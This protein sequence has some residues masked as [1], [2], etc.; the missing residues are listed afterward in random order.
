[1]GTGIFS[2]VFLCAMVAL[3][4]FG[5]LGTLVYLIY[6]HIDEKEFDPKLFWISIGFAVLVGFSIVSIV[7]FSKYES[8]L[9]T[10]IMDLKS[11]KAHN[12]TTLPEGYEEI[13]TYD[14]F[15]NEDNQWK[16]A[17]KC[18]SHSNGMIEF[19]TFEGEHIYTNNTA[20]ITE[21]IEVIHK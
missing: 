20:L 7:D 1:M 5:L 18:I 11:S 9:K 12:K 16:N 10:E 21:H 14:I 15:I 13:R 19:T 17:T 6:K 4:G 3:L 8:K 2:T